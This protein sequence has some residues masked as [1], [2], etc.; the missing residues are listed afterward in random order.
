M[1]N[2][3]LQ[4]MRTASGIVVVGGNVI[5]DSIDFTS[6]NISYNP[7]TGVITFNE[8]GRYIIDWWVATQAT[9]SAIGVVFSLTSSQSYVIKG[10]SP[11]KTGE[12]SGIGIIDVASAPMTLSL[13]NSSAGNVSYSTIVPIK[14]SLI[15]EQ[16]DNNIG[17]TGPTGPTGDTGAT[18]PTGPT[19]LTGNTGATGPTG[20]TG[21]TGN[22]G[23][24]GPTGPTGPTGNTGATGPTGPTGPTGDTGA[25]GPTGPTGLTGDT[26]ATGPTGPTGI[27]GDTGATGATGPTGPTG[28][29]GTAGATGPTGPTGNTGATGPTGPTGITG[30]TGATGATGPTG[31]T[32]NTGATGPTGPTG[33][34]GNTGATGATG[35]TGPTGDTGA[36]GATGPTGP[37][38]NT[39][40]TGP[41]GNTGATGPTGPT[42]SGAMIPFASGNT[43][44]LTT[45]AG[46]LAGIPGFIGFGN[47]ALGITT[48]G[49]TIDLT[50]STGTSLD[51]AFSVPR[52]GT[53]TSIAAYF[54]TTVAL[55][56]VGSTITITAQLY[57]STTPDN[58][59]TPVAG[60]AV[61]LSPALT[62]II[63]AGTV[64]NAILT[65]LSIPVT[66]QTRLLMVFSA[67]AAGLSLLN[68]VDGYASAGVNLT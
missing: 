14:A 10:D 16:N 34:T 24:T 28:N 33:L 42:G 13:V 63:A 65:G 51:F 7:V 55:A 4:I 47:S 25:T 36:T 3:A 43:V 48:L 20:P 58:T 5:F 62:A 29:T 1:S 11:I 40:A 31:P 39:G 41:T 8:V 12:V 57:S 49:S 64:S 35:P 17:P 9:N 6:G 19:G 60:T 50:G 26:G 53:I 37:T 67:T 56:L 44:A 32:G 2:I 21:L 38:G 66:A 23:A 27:T 59:F 45:I 22:T 52:S 54:S 68:T 15:I 61:T 46:G 30:D 18:G